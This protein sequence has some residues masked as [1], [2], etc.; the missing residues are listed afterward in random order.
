[1]EERDVHPE[2]YSTYK[3]STGMKSKVT[4]GKG[5]GEAGKN[6]NSEINNDSIL[7]P[8]EIVRARNTQGDKADI[9]SPPPQWRVPHD[10][11]CYII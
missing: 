10:T 4:G 2:V 1:M 8:E 11:Y 5:G 6:I 3:C 9:V 7:I